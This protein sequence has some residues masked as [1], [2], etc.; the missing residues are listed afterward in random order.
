MST[1]SSFFIFFTGFLF[2]ILVGFIILRNS[3]RLGSEEFQTKF[4]TLVEGLRIE[5]GW[6][7]IW[8]VLGVLRIMITVTILILLRDYPCLEVLSLIF[9]SYLF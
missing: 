7:I 9:V 5:E 8:N 4:G 2:P 3:Q 6:G 1:I